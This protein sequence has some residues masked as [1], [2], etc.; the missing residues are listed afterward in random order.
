[1]S[2]MTVSMTFKLGDQAT[3]GLKDIES[4]FK[5]LQK[6][7]G[8]VNGQLAT[9]SKTSVGAEVTAAVQT[10]TAATNE[11]MATEKMLRAANLEDIRRSEIT[12]TAKQAEVD[13][14]SGL[15]LAQRV[16]MAEQIRLAGT[17]AA[18]SASNYEL[19]ASQ[20]VAAAGISV[21]EK[22]LKM[23]AIIATNMIRLNMARAETMA[24]M[25]LETNVATA[26]TIKDTEALGAH[27]AATKVNALAM[28]ES[29]VLVREFSRGDISRMAGSSTILLQSFGK[30][31]MLFSWWTVG[32]AAIGALGYAAEKSAEKFNAM[33]NAIRLTGNY[34]NMTADAAHNL[35]EQMADTGRISVT[36]SEAVVQ[37]LVASGQLG[38]KVLGELAGMAARYAQATGEDIKVV[39]GN[40]IKVFEDPYKGALKLNQAWHFLNAA[41]IEHI[42]LLQE[43][44]DKEGAQLVLGDAMNVQLGTMKDRLS[45]LG[46][47]FR[48]LK[49]DIVGAYDALGNFFG[50]M[51][52]EDTT[53]E[54]LAKAKGVVAQFTRHG[55]NAEDVR[56]AQNQVTFLETKLKMESA[57]AAKKSEQTKQEAEWINLQES[58]RKYAKRGGETDD[59]DAVIKGLRAE[60]AARTDLIKVKQGQEALDNNASLAKAKE[61][62]H[63]AELA[64]ETM[65]KRGTKG[66]STVMQDLREKLA[67]QK[68]DLAA[69]GANQRD[70]LQLEATFWAQDISG[71]KLT[72]AERVKIATVA[73]NAQT[74][75]EIYDNKEGKRLEIEKLDNLKQA[76]DAAIAAKMAEIKT[77]RVVGPDAAVQQLA[78]ERELLVEKLALDESYD[79]AKA[80]IDAKYQNAEDKQRAQNLATIKA[81]D[82]AALVEDNKMWAGLR[83]NSTTAL[84]AMLGDAQKH[85]ASVTAVFKSMLGSISQGFM[86]LVNQRLSQQ[87]MNSM[88]GTNSNTMTGGGFG[89]LLTMFGINQGNSNSAGAWANQ[90]FAGGNGQWESY[91]VGTDYVPRDMIAQIHQ[92]ERILTAD[93]NRNFTGGSAQVTNHNYISVNEPTNTRTQSQIFAGIA[94]ATGK[95]A[96][97]NN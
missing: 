46:R 12:V 20:R 1:M 84:S 49:N 75:L 31:N 37:Q 8:E 26:A 89:S 10:Q 25:G 64:R 77:V 67:A 27:A 56:N 62:L 60:I 90:S 86:T 47:R 68:E 11:L 40:L 3:A 85:G 28:K 58:A 14:V 19:A 63:S 59:V 7:V 55:G 88:F 71:F 39:A 73:R 70:M 42:R 24:I 18:L 97:R 48:S 43:S 16:A 92:G 57:I 54:Q 61:Q 38:N 2:D 21:E 72:Q 22:A 34:S 96:R 74:A 30:L 66:D 5:S 78:Q 50:R 80:A 79:A 95:A 81:N 35:A 15:T 45:P 36:A 87:L 17:T 6:T 52:R 23:E 93:E 44:G 91:A 65:L 82:N 4:S 53:T 41:Q 9:F 76:G 29:V 32:I 83:S 33:N 13:A 94:A 51:L 69:T